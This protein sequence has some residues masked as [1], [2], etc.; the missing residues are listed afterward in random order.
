MT[1][2]IFEVKFKPGEEIVITLRNPMRGER[3]AGEAAAGESA[4]DAAEPPP[5]EQLHAIGTEVLKTARTVLDAV[6]EL[7]GE[8]PA[9]PTRTKRRVKVE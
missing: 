2:N 8:K 6:I 3:P 7:L 1:E 4:A 9:E 5:V